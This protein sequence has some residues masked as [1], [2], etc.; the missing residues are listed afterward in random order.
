[1]RPNVFLKPVLPAVNS[2]IAL[3][4]QQPAPPAVVSLAVGGEE[5]K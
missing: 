1:V 2:Y 4:R 5:K 3:S